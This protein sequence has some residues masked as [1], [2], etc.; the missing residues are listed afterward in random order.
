MNVQHDKI[1]PLSLLDQVFVSCQQAYSIFTKEMI[2][3]SY[4]CVGKIGDVAIQYVQNKTFNYP[5]WSLLSSRA[6]M[7]SDVMF[8]WP[9]ITH[10]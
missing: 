7:C 10:N 8:S 4:T 6:T 3:I 9:I 2:A 1:Y 5:T